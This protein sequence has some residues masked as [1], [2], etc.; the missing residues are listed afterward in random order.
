VNGPALP[1]QRD[2]EWSLSINEV[3][4]LGDIAAWLRYA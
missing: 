3:A 1:V 4:P 2:R